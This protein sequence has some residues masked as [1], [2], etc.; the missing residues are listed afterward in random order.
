[1]NRAIKKI[2][3][4]DCY[5]TSGF[6]KRTYEYNGRIVTDYHEG[7]DY[8]TNAKSINVYS[9]T[10]GVVIFTGYNS[11]RGNYIDVDYNINNHRYRGRFQHLQSIKVQKGQQVNSNTIIGTTGQSGQATGIHLHLEWYDY[12]LRKNINF[13]TWKEPS[14]TPIPDDSY[15]IY[16]IAYGDTLTSI[17]EQF[18][19][20][21]TDLVELN[22]IEDRN[23]IIAGTKLKIPQ[24]A[25][26]DLKVGT[27]VKIVGK[28]ANSADA[29]TANNT[30]AIGWERT[31]L[32]IIPNANYPYMVGSG[33]IAT[34]FFK[35]EALQKL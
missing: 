6:G 5:V 12:T 3:H 35:R 13:E 18:H 1:M 16:T 29:K 22:Q 26:T 17:A 4:D 33:T 32:K 25:T 19:T 14:P 30:A 10:N 21:V 31:I 34:G 27:K 23:Y 28:Y 7:V 24:K 8:G 11:D 15:F 2:L 20:T 9:Y